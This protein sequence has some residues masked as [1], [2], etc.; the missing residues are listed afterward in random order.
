[1]IFQ[2]AKWIS[3]PEHV[4]DPAPEYRKS[5][6][7]P[8][9][10]EAAEAR[11]TITALGVY[12]ARI[13]GERVGAYVLA[14]GW[15]AYDKRLQVQT[16]D[17][18]HLIRGENEISVLVG[19]GWYASR[20]PG[21]FQS[22]EIANRR[23]RQTG[24]IAELCIRCT[25]GSEACIGTDG[26]WTWRESGIRF[27][28]IYD[29]ETCDAG[30]T[31]GAEQP[32]ALMN[33]GM[34]TLIP[35]EGEEIREME[36]VA[37]ASVFRTPKGEWVVDFG[38]EITGYVE[39]TVDAK[40]G[41]RIRILHGEMLDKEGNFYNENYRSAKA[42][43]NYICR[44]GLQTWHP[45]LTFF[46]FRYLKLD[47]FPGEPKPEQFTGIAVYSD[48]RQTGSIRTG[49]E[50]LNRLISNI[51][52]GQRGNFLDIPTD[53]PQRDERLGWTG[54]AQVFS[55]AVTLN[56]DVE[57]FFTK[58]LHDLAA[59]QRAD[60]GVGSVY[61]D[62]LP[63]DQSS[64]AWGD[65]AT[66]IPWQVYQTYG[67]AAILRSQFE[68][69]KKWVGYVTGPRRKRTCGSAE[70]TSATGLGWTR[71]WEATR[72]RRGRT[73]SRAPITRGRRSWS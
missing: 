65:A 58:W 26:S 1:M 61:P 2:K 28:E 4:G 31:A 52:W 57:R 35:Q 11:L 66:I 22:E 29:G 5:W 17:V 48:I 25:D 54:D 21:W 13:N 56:F 37:A 24:L 10:K 8:E 46:G 36:R 63:A 55:K 33:A 30:F 47:A 45:Q 71:R 50:N 3:I 18:T 16:Y 60:G 69:M 15:T 43:I 49:H 14:P 32:C 70:R 9:G 27:S 67:D 7:L 23:N 53:C 42:E 72:D 6:Q 38:Q 41:D 12:E 51:F 64:A 40:A 68:S 39:F 73:S 62:Y 34:E 59:D 20:M 19:K 44:E